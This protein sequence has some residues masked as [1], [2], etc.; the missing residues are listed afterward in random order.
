MEISSF[1]LFDDDHAYSTAILSCRDR[2]MRKFKPKIDGCSEE[3]W[4]LEEVIICII[5]MV[6]E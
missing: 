3:E 2:W 5:C 4:T 1:L 6:V